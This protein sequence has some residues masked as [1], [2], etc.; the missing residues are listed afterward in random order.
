MLSHLK[1]YHSLPSE[2]LSFLMEMPIYTCN[3]RILLEQNDDSQD[4]LMKIF[5]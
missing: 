4:Y 2:I 3:L 5:L 1:E